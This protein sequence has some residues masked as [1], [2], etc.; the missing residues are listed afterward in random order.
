MRAVKIRK[1]SSERE[2]NVSEF[3]QYI[4]IMSFLVMIDLCYPHGMMECWNNGVVRIKIG[5][6]R[7]IFFFLST[8]YS[9][10]PLFQYS[11]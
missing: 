8:H 9:S 6:N 5:K 10:I 1:G 11:S 7:F 4:E 3:L 2:L